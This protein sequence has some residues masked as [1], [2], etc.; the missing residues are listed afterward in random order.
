MAGLG[1]KL[2]TAFSKL[3][4]AQ[5]NGYLMD[6]SIM[7]FASVAV[8]DAAFG[9]VGEPSLAEGMTC[10]LD[11]LNVLQTYTG[12]AWVSISSPSGS[13]VQ[14]K[15]T[16]LNTTTSTT[17]TTATDVA[18]FSVSITPTSATSKVLVTVNLHVG[19]LSADDTSYLLLRGSTAISVGTG[20]TNN[21]SAYKRG[22]IISD[23]GMDTVDIVFLDSPATTSATTYKMQ[24]FTRVGTTFVNR[25]GSDTS[26]ITSSSI[27]V[28]EISA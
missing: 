1:A 9:G 3:T 10:Y 24:Y 28:Q 13:V 15:Q 26:F 27:T 17:S 25:R 23:T 20:G 6:Q 18:G 7:R 19:F 11:D 16:V 5:V 22:N 12:T 4:A 21:I 14:T 8:R 2:F